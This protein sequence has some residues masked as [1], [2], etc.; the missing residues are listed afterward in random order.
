MGISTQNVIFPLKHLPN[1]YAFCTLICQGEK[2]KAEK[3]YKFNV[4]F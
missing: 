1:C 3:K 4:T 2:K